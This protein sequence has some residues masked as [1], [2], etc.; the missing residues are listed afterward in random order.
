MNYWRM[1]FRWGTGGYE[2]WDNCYKKGVAALG[3]YDSRMRPIVGDCTGMSEND[4]EE[5]WRKRRPKSGSARS[6]L[7]NFVYVM[8]P[9]DIIYAKQGPNIVGKGKVASGYLYDAE[10]M[11]DHDH[12]HDHYRK[13]RWD[14]SFQDF[15]LAV[16]ADHFTLLLLNK[17]RLSLIRQAERRQVSDSRLKAATEGKLVRS[18]VS[19]RLRNSAL[20]AAK[21]A[22]SNYRCE[23]CGMRFE[24]VY[25][26]IGRKHIVAHHVK[27]I[28]ARKRAS[29]TKLDDIALVCS[30]CHDM[31]H[32]H[33]TLRTLEELRGRMKQA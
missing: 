27:P 1:S 18:E 25:G 6:S 5:A 22:L 31:L 3:Y 17:A 21:K 14:P 12:P 10:V 29:V 26:D 28:G 19:F 15:H 32:R 33:G 7:R 13:V 23:V 4:F 11:N 30:N 24:D 16:G 9:G 20:I 8:R 2:L